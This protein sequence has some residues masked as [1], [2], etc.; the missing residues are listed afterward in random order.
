MVDRITLTCS[1]YVKQYIIISLF[2]RGIS[3]RSCEKTATLDYS[4]KKYE[5]DEHVKAYLHDR[6]A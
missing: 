4:I 5:V 3:I 1:K 6:A 2:K